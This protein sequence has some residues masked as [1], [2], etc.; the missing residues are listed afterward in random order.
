MGDGSRRKAAIAFGI[1]SV[2]SVVGTEA[3][4]RE[5]FQVGFG[6]GVGSLSRD[7]LTTQTGLSG[8][9]GLGIVLSEN[10]VIG[11]EASMW[12]KP[13]G[14]TTRSLVRPALY[15]FPGASSGLFFKVAAEFVRLSTPTSSG[16]SSLGNRG[17]GV[18]IGYDVFLGERLSMR[19]I[20]YY[21]IG[22]PGGNVTI[23]GEI[24]VGLSWRPG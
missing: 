13:A 9:V 12:R 24:T 11:V 22:D 14:L 18:G 4:T 20:V 16:R 19:P 10:V 3:Q 7:G 8:Y 6:L 23:L 2:L 15:I 1:C 21:S 17:L 5:G